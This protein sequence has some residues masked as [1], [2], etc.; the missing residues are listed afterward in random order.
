MAALGLAGESVVAACPVSIPGSITP[1]PDTA[2]VITASGVPRASPKP[3]SFAARTEGNVGPLTKNR[4]GALEP[5]PLLTTTCAS[6]STV[7]YGTWATILPGLME[8]I[9]A[10]LLLI[11]TSQSASFSG[12]GNPGATTPSAGPR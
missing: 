2:R 5:D 3:R 8:P 10:G 7:S 12:Q 4:A 1:S 9:G 11:R 6:P